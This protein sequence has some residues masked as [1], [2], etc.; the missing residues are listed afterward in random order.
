MSSA[1]HSD[2]LLHMPAVNKLFAEDRNLT[3]A[4]VLGVLRWQLQLD[5]VMRSML[6]RPDGE[7]HPA[8]LLAL[9]MG[10]FQILHMDRIPAH[11][12]V[13]ESVEMAKQNGADRSAGMVNAVLRRV[14]Q[15]KETLK[16]VP[17]IAPLT[18][19]EQAHPMW[20]LERWRAQFGKAAAR[21]IAAYDQNEPPSGG[22]YAQ[23]DGLPQIDDGSRL[24]A[25]LAAAAVAEPKRILDCCA[26]PGGK[27]AVLA[28]RHPQAEI[29]ACDNSPKRLEALRRRMDRHDTMK[30]VKTLLADM[31]KPHEEL[32]EG[33]FDLILCDAPCSGT[34]TLARNPEIRHR[35]RESD[36]ARQSQRQKAI[37]TQALTL[38]A[39]GGRLVYSTCSLE[40]EENLEVVQSTS[41]TVVDAA[42]LV[43]ASAATAVVDGVLRT[44]PGTLPCDGF[45]AAVLTR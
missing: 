29:V 26:A 1:A 35:L 44:L 28:V 31:T 27:T 33:S 38:L 36:L 17:L 3:T 13:N 37:L 7:M 39:P 11:A 2:D 25:E 20:M 15:E 43:P 8:A 45:F 4:L 10:I 30:Q 23:E 5:N 40:P 16:R 21:K 9:R 24:V 42:S 18:L 22:L 14:M 19:E 6:Q 12:A 34:G 32:A 41:A